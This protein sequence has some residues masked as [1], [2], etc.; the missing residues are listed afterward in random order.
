MIQIYNELRSSAPY[1]KSV[2]WYNNWSDTLYII[3]TN[4][5]SFFI[6]ES[7]QVIV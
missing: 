3:P 4:K 1:M 5:N 7:N 6:C 2:S